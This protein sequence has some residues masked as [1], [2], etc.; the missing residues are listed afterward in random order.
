MIAM[1]DDSVNAKR[2]EEKTNRVGK[3]TLSSKV[4]EGGTDVLNL[5]TRRDA[6]ELTKAESLLTSKDTPENP[7]WVKIGLHTIAHYT[8]DP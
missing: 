8:T 3:D 4:K 5:R 2:G 1:A 7:L 6:I